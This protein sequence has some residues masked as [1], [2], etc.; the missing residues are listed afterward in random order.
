MVAKVAICEF[1]ANVYAET[2]GTGITLS[3]DHMTRSLQ[4]NLDSAL[5][6]L[7]AAV[8]VFSVKARQYFDPSNTGKQP[9][10]V[11]SQNP[12]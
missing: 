3:S 8:L 1:Y 9:S 11:I 7:Y 12:F 4:Q 6:E 2:L 5:P 10:M